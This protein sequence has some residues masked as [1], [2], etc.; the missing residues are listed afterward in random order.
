[1]RHELSKSMMLSCM[2]L[3]GA[4]SDPEIAT[5]PTYEVQLSDFEIVIPGFG[6][7]EAAEAQNIA[8]PG[9]RPMVIEWLAEENSR[10][11]KGQVVARFDAE[12]LLLDSRE[13]ELE[14]LLLEKDMRKTYAE[15]AKQENDLNSE[16]VFVGKEFEFVDTFAIDD[17]RL[18]SKIEIIDTL[19]NRDYLGAKE[20]FI[21]WKQDSIGERNQ[22]AVQ[23]LDIRKQ[24][25]EQKFQQHQE[26]LSLLEIYAPYDGLLVYEKNFRGDKPSIGQTVFPGSTIAKIPNLEHMQAKIYVLDKDAIGLK[27]GQAVEL[28]LEASPDQILIG[29]ISTVSGFSR[30][31]QRGNPT[32]YFELTVEIPNSSVT[33]QPAQ[34]VRAKIK[35]SPLTQ[36]ITIPLQAIF[37]EKGENFV[38]LQKGS[39]FV[40]QNVSTAVKNLHFVEIIEGLNAGDVIALSVPEG[41]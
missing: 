23:I 38:Y 15:K 18:Y 6:E 8:A 25:H 10:V 36:K 9:R 33:L 17:M 27:E 21:D 22:S 34:K 5:I 30:T 13:E 1:M 40:K 12:L 31:V 3:L 37:N 14:M 35:A 39:E 16:E 19:S 11:T 41:V 7:L 20:E 4:C 29:T 28:T 24:G 32:K 2:L 26:A